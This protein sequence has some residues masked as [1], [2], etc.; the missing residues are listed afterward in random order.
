MNLVKFTDCI[1]KDVYIVTNIP[2]CFF[3]YLLAIM[4]EVAIN[5]HVLVTDG[6]EMLRIMRLL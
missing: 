3:C 6:T 4:N 5:I 1:T 2:V